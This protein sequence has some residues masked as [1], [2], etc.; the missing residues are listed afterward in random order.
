[1][2]PIQQQHRRR[3]SIG[4]IVVVATTIVASILY[5]T[6]H[7]NIEHI[8]SNNLHYTNNGP[9]QN[10]REL[11]SLI[12][13]EDPKAVQLRATALSDSTPTQQQQPLVEYDE[14]SRSNCKF[15]ITVGVEGSMHHGFSPMLQKLASSQGF[16]QPSNRA[17]HYFSR[18]IYSLNGI[19]P[20][21]EAVQK[22]MNI[23]CPKDG[24]KRLYLEGKSW[25]NG[26]N[27]RDPNWK[28]MTPLQI[29]MSE[30]ALNSP[31]NLYDL[32]DV[33]SPYADIKFVALHRP[34][35]QTIASHNGGAMRWDGG[36]IIH[37]NII[38]GHMT[39]LREF[40]DSHMIDKRTRQRLWTT[41][42]TEKLLTKN[43]GNK[44]ATLETGNDIIMHHLEH[45]LGWSQ[46]ACPNC[47]DDW[48]EDKKN[49]FAKIRPKEVETVQNHIKTL[50]GVWPPVDDTMPL[51]LQQCTI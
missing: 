23:I 27:N 50:V 43:H 20:S 13:Y 8:I 21:P 9:S 48:Q 25:P 18:A 39:M 40:L 47:F 28:I 36:A 49:P 16:E 17:Q 45:F 12:D 42:C 22:T 15:V 5:A 24:H 33:Y 1:M 44:E 6:T 31:T 11:S 30:I 38:R 32:M 4:A 51:Y 34:Y 29:S 37:S 35:L 3:A 7:Q 26:R 19:K 2:Q 10:R 41:V 14:E 46:N